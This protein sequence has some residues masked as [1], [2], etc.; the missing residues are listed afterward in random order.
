MKIDLGGN[1]VIEQAKVARCY[2]DKR[3]LLDFS[4]GELTDIAEQAFQNEADPGTGEK[5]VALV[6]RAVF[7]RI[8]MAI[9]RCWE[10]EG[11]EGFVLINREGIQTMPTA[12][13]TCTCQ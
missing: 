6:G 10:Y 13:Q 2:L 11:F 5:W 12:F 7:S 9:P 8:L 1:V 3:G 4:G